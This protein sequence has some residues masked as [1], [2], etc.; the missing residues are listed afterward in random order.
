MSEAALLPGR[1]PRRI[2]CVHSAEN[3]HR[4]LFPD[5]FSDFVCAFNEVALGACIFLVVYKL[6]AD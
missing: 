5:A 3:R 2:F 6:D 4:L 1:S